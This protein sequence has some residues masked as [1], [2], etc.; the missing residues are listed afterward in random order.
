VRRGLWGGCT[1]PHTHPFEEERSETGVA[2][3]SIDRDKGV[4]G[5]STQH[6]FEEER[7]EKREERRAR[8][9]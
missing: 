5:G 3:V 6:S 4:V 2:G 7:R 9:T 1:Q 8:S